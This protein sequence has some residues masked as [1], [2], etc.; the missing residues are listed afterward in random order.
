M[1]ETDYRFEEYKRYYPDTVKATLTVDKNLNKEQ[2]QKLAEQFAEIQNSKVIYWNVSGRKILIYTSA[3]F[4]TVAAKLV[5]GAKVMVSSKKYSRNIIIES[6]GVIYC[7]GEAAVS[8]RSDVP[9]I[10]G[11]CSAI[12][13]KPKESEVGDEKS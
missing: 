13:F 9:E 8:V 7:A 3:K 6:D 2:T 10:N 5:K 11:L 12:F 4:K 1:M